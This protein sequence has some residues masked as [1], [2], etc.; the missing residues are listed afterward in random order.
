MTTFPEYPRIAWKP[1]IGG[2]VDYDDGTVSGTID[3]A[4]SLGRDFWGWDDTAAFW[5]TSDSTQGQLAD[6]LSAATGA[7]LTAKYLWPYGAQVPALVGW[8]LTHTANLD[9]VFTDAGG[10]PSTTVAAQFG[11]ASSSVIITTLATKLADF[12]CAGSW[13]PRQRAATDERWPFNANVGV[14]ESIDG[15]ARVLRTWGATLTRRALTFPAVYVADIRTDAAA[16]ATYAD[17]A[18]R[19]A[20]DPNCILANL[21]AACRSAVNGAAPELRVF[22]D[23]ATY[24][25]AYMLEGLDELEPLCSDASAR[26]IWSVSLTLRDNG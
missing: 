20:A 6:L 8:S 16:L 25:S 5:A 21:L 10:T 13:A 17:A 11:F 1:E 14:S 18:G 24:R 15:S 3:L 4:S 9:L 7:T 19:D 22:T 12:Q 2:Q 23:A 26:R